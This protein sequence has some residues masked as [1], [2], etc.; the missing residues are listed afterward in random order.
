VCD[1]KDGGRREELRIGSCRRIEAQVN[2]DRWYTTPGQSA[3]LYGTP[4]GG[5]RTGDEDVRGRIKRGQIANNPPCLGR[6]RGPVHR[7]FDGIETKA[8]ET[9][10]RSP[11][12]VLE[13]W[14]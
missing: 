2:L 3:V 12:V 10:P 8:T 4:W 9:T 7:A 1:R 6:L 13:S 14:S 5:Q 11:M